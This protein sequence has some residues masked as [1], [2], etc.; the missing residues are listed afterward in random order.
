MLTASRCFRN[1]TISKLRITVAMCL[2]GQAI[3][4]SYKADKICPSLPP[5][6]KLYYNNQ[7]CRIPLSQPSCVL[8][9]DTDMSASI[10]LRNFT[11][12][13]ESGPG[14]DGKLSHAVR[15]IQCGIRCFKMRTALAN[16]FLAS[17]NLFSVKL[18]VTEQNWDNY[19]ALKRH[20]WKMV[21]GKIA[22]GLGENHYYP[23]G[24]F[25]P[26]ITV[27]PKI[28]GE[29]NP[30]WINNKRC[31]ACYKSTRLQRNS[32]C[33]LCRLQ[34]CR[35]CVM[36]CKE[37]DDLP[38]LRRIK[39]CE[40]CYAKQCGFQLEQEWQVDKNSEPAGEPLPRPFLL[41]REWVK[42]IHQ[43]H[44]DQLGEQHEQECPE[45]KEYKGSSAL[46]RRRLAD[47]LRSPILPR[48]SEATR[49]RAGAF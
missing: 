24:R 10:T 48:F 42:Y 45:C 22:L 33:R 30:L 41:R 11:S 2:L 8:C 13:K 47:I 43:R 6:N 7:V 36:I 5:D 39:Y 19:V 16:D 15:Q 29:E 14:Y 4:A 46:E 12:A 40:S 38:H 27:Y 9:G 21:N 25:Q 49:R 28:D 17:K 31:A 32:H 3:G 20:G 44:A 35:E 37:R 26:Y 18:Q 34:F 23:L 1:L